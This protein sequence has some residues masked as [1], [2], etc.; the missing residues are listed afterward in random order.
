MVYLV[1]GTQFSVNLFWKCSILC[2]DSLLNALTGRYGVVGKHTVYPVPKERS[3]ALPT[4]SKAQKC[5]I[6]AGNGVGYSRGI[7]HNT[8]IPL[9]LAPT[10][11]WPQSHIYLIEQHL[12]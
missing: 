3:Y 8:F 12:M 11:L 6:N 9:F 7:R 4:P 2:C 5:F 1:T 10:N